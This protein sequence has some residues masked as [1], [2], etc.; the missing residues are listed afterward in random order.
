M[1]NKKRKKY[2]RNNFN[3]YEYEESCEDYIICENCGRKIS[4]WDF[5]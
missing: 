2:K 1:R 3:E 5:Y 4:E